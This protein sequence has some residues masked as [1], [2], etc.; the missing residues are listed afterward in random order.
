MHTEKLKKINI[1]CEKL[2]S[3]AKEYTWTNNCLVASIILHEVLKVLGIETR[4]CNGFL[5][6]SNQYMIKHFFIKYDPT[7]TTFDPCNYTMKIE[8]FVTEF[9]M[10]YERIDLDNE[11]EK[12][13]CGHMIQAYETYINNS[14]DYWDN[15]ANFVNTKKEV[16]VEIKNA[17][18][19]FAFEKN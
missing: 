1:L 2:V 12:K 13:V 18:A 14:K 16:I 8:K 15:P 19:K 6:L 11:E 4:I 10:P 7:R 3:L 17:L 5:I 9:N